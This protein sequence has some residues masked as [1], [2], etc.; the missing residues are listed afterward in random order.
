MICQQEND[1]LGDKCKDHKFGCI[2]N[3]FVTRQ[4]LWKDGVHLTNNG[5]SVFASNAVNF[6]NDFI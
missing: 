6:L 5:T 2:S 3:D 1:L 4:F